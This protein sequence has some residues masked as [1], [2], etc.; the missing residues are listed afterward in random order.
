MSYARLTDSATCQYCNFSKDRTYP[1]KVLYDNEVIEVMLN[2]YKEMLVNPYGYEECVEG[3][4]FEVKYC[5]ICG[6]KL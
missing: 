3:I 4:V 6:R 5:P 1:T 2:R